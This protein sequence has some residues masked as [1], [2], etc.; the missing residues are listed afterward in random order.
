MRISDILWN[1]PHSGLHNESGRS[2]TGVARSGCG[3]M[4]NVDAD[5]PETTGVPPVFLIECVRRLGQRRFRSRGICLELLGG[6]SVEARRPHVGSGARANGV[7][8]MVE[9]ERL[10]LPVGVPEIEHRQLGIEGARGFAAAGALPRGVEPGDIAV[11][12]QDAAVL[13]DSLLC[14][15]MEKEAAAVGETCMGAL[16]ASTIPFCRMSQNSSETPKLWAGAVSA[17][18]AC[19]S[20]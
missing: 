10:R 16:T 18:D 12:E 7:R 5:R 11:V 14:A 4:K 13:A 15:E 6:Q 2:A 17:R 3:L 1:M 20:R 19:A 8:G 9:D